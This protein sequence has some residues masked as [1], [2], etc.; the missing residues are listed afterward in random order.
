MLDIA[1]ELAELLEQ[2]RDEVL[3]YKDTEESFPWGTRSFS[4]ELKG[5][6]FLFI[7]EQ[8]DHL[9]LI[10]RVPVQQKE[11][12]LNLPFGEVHKSMGER[13]W[14]SARIK[15][16]EEL[17]EIR[18][19]LKVSYEMAKPFRGPADALPGEKVEVL[20]FLAKVRHKANTFPDVEEY[21]PFGDRAF[22]SRKGQIFLYAGEQDEALYVSVRLPFGEREFALSLP[23]VEVPRY[24]GHKGWVGV[25]VRNQDDLNIVLPWIDISYEENKPKR[26][27]KVKK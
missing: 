10:F 19:M 6:N 18:P 23:N 15:T 13:G 8:K 16:Q 22:R 17:D 20:D 9:E 5:R 14:L 21:F 7:Y 12:V 25:K 11:A 27:T 24:I 3:S 26:K 1:P 2:V 4:R